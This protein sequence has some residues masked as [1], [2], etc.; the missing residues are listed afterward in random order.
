MRPLFLVFLV[1]C[2]TETNVEPN[3]SDTESVECEAFIR[4]SSPENGDTEAYYRTYVEFYLSE[5]V[6]E[7][8]VDSGVPGTTV[9]LDGGQT[10]RFIPDEPLEQRT[11]YTFSLELCGES[12]PLTFETSNTGNPLEVLPEELQQ[13]SYDLSLLEVDFVEGELLGNL[14]AWLYRGHLL[15]GISEMTDSQVSWRVATAD[16]HGTQQDACAR[17]LE[18]PPAELSGTYFSLQEPELVFDA[19]DITLRALDVS[20]EGDFTVDGSAI[21]GLRFSALF[22]GR[23]L[24][25]LIG[26]DDYEAMCELGDFANMPCQPCPDDGSPTCFYVEVAQYEAPSTPAVLVEVDQACEED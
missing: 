1:G 20:L 9:M 13:Q 16:A 3:P 19:Y 6:E 5:P 2:V 14:V 18:L 24:I 11:E 15:A 10:V 22:D 26:G 8:A 4:G 21:D 23:E 12:A 17:T 25:A 7:V